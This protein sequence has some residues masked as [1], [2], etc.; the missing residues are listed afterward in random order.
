[1]KKQTNNKWK[2]WLTYLAIFFL[3]LVLAPSGDTTEVCPDESTWRELKVVD[4]RGFQL[5][6][7]GFLIAGDMVMVIDD[8][9]STAFYEYLDQMNANNVK[10]EATADR[11]LE[12]LARLGY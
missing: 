11:R 3:G 9:D 2:K 10:I 5:A 1:M 8:A 12:I 6:S 7:D 4:D